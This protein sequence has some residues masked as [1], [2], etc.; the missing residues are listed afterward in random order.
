MKADAGYAASEVKCSQ[1]PPGAG[2]D[3][4]APRPPAVP[5][6][7]SLGPQPEGNPFRN[8]TGSH[9]SYARSPRWRHCSSTA[10]QASRVYRRNLA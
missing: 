2:E 4:R 7:D 9:S 6:R 8:A 5:R 10:K 1:D 3:G